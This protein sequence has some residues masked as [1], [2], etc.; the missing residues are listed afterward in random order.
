[1]YCCDTNSYYAGKII[2]Y[3]RDNLS[4][5]DT[6]S[7]GLSYDHE[8]GWREDQDVYEIDAIMEIVAEKLQ[9]FLGREVQVGCKYRPFGWQ[10]I[11]EIGEVK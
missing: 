2:Q 11:V 4:K 5:K 1:M 3:V 9:G 7:Y 8:N 6:L 10:I